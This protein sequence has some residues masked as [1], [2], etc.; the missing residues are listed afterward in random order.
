[1]KLAIRSELPAELQEILKDSRFALILPDEWGVPKIIAH[2]N[3]PVLVSQAGVKPEFETPTSDQK[4][5]IIE[6]MESGQS[7]TSAYYDAGIK[8]KSRHI[9]ISSGQVAA[10]N[11][12][13]YRI[14][15]SRRAV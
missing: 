3:D 6:L 7:K 11:G 10:P 12:V 2:G 8:I 14:D 4:M 9:Y 13:F 5:Q 1:M 15:E